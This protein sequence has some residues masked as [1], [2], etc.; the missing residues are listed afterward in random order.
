MIKVLWPSNRAILTLLFVA[1]GAV[2][3]GFLGARHIAAVGSELD[4]LEN[5]SLDWRHTLGGIR[6][7]PRGVVI[8]AIDDETIARAGSFPISRSM[9]ARIVRSLA[10]GDP[11]VIAVDVLL[12]DPGPPDA[13]RELVEA[14]Q[15]TK[16][17]IGAIAVF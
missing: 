5:V 2:W 1:L 3:G 17:V 11:Q 6:E 16:T 7:A 14:L 13:D 4:R 15:S 12:L 10:A 9:L 8:A